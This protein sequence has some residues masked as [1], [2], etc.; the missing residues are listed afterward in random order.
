MKSVRNIRTD[1]H[2]QI[3]IRLRICALRT[4]NNTKIPNHTDSH[5][6]STV[7]PALSAVSTQITTTAV[8]Y[9]MHCNKFRFTL[10][11]SKM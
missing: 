5:N 8:L 4:L 2:H 7:L 1:G 6:R 9:M 10:L 11:P 3:T